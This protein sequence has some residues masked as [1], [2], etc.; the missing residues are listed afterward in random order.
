MTEPIFRQVAAFGHFGRADL[1][2]GIMLRCC[3][4]VAAGDTGPCEERVA[5]PNRL[6]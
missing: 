1:H 5:S 2:L 3:P 6:T 4:G